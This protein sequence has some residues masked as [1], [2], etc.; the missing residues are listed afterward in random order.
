MK[1]KF[2]LAGLLFSLF[3]SVSQASTITSGEI[4]NYDGDGDGQDDDLLIAQVFFEVSAGTE[5]LIDSLV[6]ESTGID[7]NSDGELTGFDNFMRLF[8]GVNSLT[9]NDDAPLGSDGSVHSYDSQI[10]YTFTDAGIYMVTV[11]QLYYDENEALA[12][13]D[14]DRA[15]PAYYCNGGNCDGYSQ[16]HA[17][18][19][20]TFTTNSGSVFNVTNG[21]LHA[22]G[23]P[24]PASLALVGLGLLAS[25]FTRGGLVN[26][27]AA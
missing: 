25:G 21:E 4:F 10:N 23:V 26:A 27:L 2:V 7:L 5:L 14:P 24:N 1:L 9:Q 19:Q 17:D 22:S 12:G 18:W 8:A 15:F 16:T 6:W 11:G 13:F 20:L 3:S